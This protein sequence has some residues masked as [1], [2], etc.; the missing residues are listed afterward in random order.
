MNT[1]WLDL[2]DSVDAAFGV[3]PTVVRHSLSGHPLLTREA[4]VDLARVMPS[5]L[6][7][8]HLGRDL[9]LVMP[10]L[11]WDIM[12]APPVEVAEN[13]EHNGTWMVFWHVEEMPEYRALLHEILDPVMALVGDRDG[14]LRPPEGYIFFSAPGCVTP[15]HVDPEHNFLLQVLGSKDFIAGG[16]PDEAA[17][18]RTAERYY[19]GDA[20][21]NL[22]WLP[23]KALEV[24]LEPGTGVYSPYL[25]PHW[26]NTGD[27]LSI[28]FS[29][30]FQTARRQQWGA[31][32]R[33][34]S[35]LRRLGLSPQPP[36]SNSAL[37]A[38]KRVAGGLLNR[39]ASIAGHRRTARHQPEEAQLATADNPYGIRLR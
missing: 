27:D 26:V 5:H 23:P 13:I 35:R 34:N 32:H 29:A 1:G 15:A 9:G 8:H 30:T 6:I 19:G 39:A 7:E 11:G 17:R 10:D 33:F 37:D 20:H 22:D 12:H 14:E 28:S 38:G 24:H 31:V 18:Q 21:R 36:G 3:A 2:D 16:Y 25:C 4:M